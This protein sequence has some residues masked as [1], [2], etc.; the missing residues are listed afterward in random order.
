MVV[1]R[2]GL[3]K[4]QEPD[5]FIELKTDAANFKKMSRE[6]GKLWVDSENLINIKLENFKNFNK[7]W[8]LRVKRGEETLELTDKDPSIRLS[9]NDEIII[10]FKLGEVE[11]KYHYEI[12]EVGA[13][14]Y[15]HLAT[16]VAPQPASHDQS[17]PL[18]A[19]CGSEQPAA[20]PKRRVTR[21]SLCF[22]Q[23]QAPSTVQGPSP[24][25]S[26]K[27]LQVEFG[28]HCILSLCVFSVF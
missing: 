12:L 21:P 5:V 26:K 16:P 14:T 17:G 3:R 23:P 18:Q 2:A 6:I 1:G 25:A 7:L 4:E 28:P 24:G 10:S 22:H 13:D 9:L 15:E 8:F 11:V 20:A 19:A 27:W